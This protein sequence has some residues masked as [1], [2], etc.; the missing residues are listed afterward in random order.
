MCLLFFQYRFL[1][2]LSFHGAADQTNNTKKT[3][4]NTT[5]FLT[6]P[7]NITYCPGD[8]IDSQKF[9]TDCLPC[10]S[11]VFKIPPLPDF[12]HEIQI[13]LWCLVLG[14]AWILPSEA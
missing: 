4:T 3:I 8:N 10:L 5:I 6:Y 7:I 13:R 1:D 2:Q 9:L 12:L 11:S 14:G